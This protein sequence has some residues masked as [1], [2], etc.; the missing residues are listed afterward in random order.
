MLVQGDIKSCKDLKG[1]KIGIQ[2]VG[3]FNEVMSRAV[4]A[5]CGLTP[6]D[7]QYI[8][9]STKG[10]VPGL[11]N[12]QI[13]TAIL[14]VDQALVA[15]KKKSDLNILVNLWETELRK[16]DRSLGRPSRSFQGGRAFNRGQALGLR[17]LRGVSENPTRDR[18]EK[19]SLPYFL[20]PTSLSRTFDEDFFACFTE[21]RD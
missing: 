1:R 8:P 4:M 3:A 17:E 13:D 9:V 18:A 14:H 10:R 12:D 20:V 19:I 16:T 21:G 7:V 11:L 15:K 6:K 2:E 5:S